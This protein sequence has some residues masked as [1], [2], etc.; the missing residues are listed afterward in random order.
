MTKTNLFILSAACLLALASC[1]QND[2]TP[3]SGNTEPATSA[4]SSSNSTAVSTPSSSSATTIESTPYVPPTDTEDVQMSVT[5]PVNPVCVTPKVQ[6]YIDAMR[7]QEQTLEHPYRVSALYGPEGFGASGVDRGDGYTGY[8][9][10]E[11]GGVD[12][13]DYLSRNDYSNTIENVP[14]SLFWTKD[15]LSYEKAFV[16]FWSKSDK[17]DLRTV[18]AKADAVSADLPNLFANTEYRFRV[19]ADGAKRYISQTGTFKTADYPRTMTMGGVKN[20]RDL[21]GYMTSY[22]KRVKQGLVYRGYEIIDESFSSHGANYNA[23]VEKVNQEVMQI[24]HEI[25]LKDSSGR[26]GRTKSCLT[27]AE[28]HPLEVVAYDSFF[29]N[30]SKA[31]VPEIFEILSKA[32]TEH[33]YFHCWGGADRTGMVAFFLNA[34]LGVSYTDLVIDFELTTETNNKRCHMHNSENAHF[35]KFL[36]A[37]AELPQFDKNKTVNEN[38]E[39][40]LT[41][42]FGIPMATIEKIRAAM[43]EDYS[44]DLAEVEPVYTADTSAW[45]ADRFGHWHAA[46][47]DPKVRCDYSRHNCVLDESKSTLPDCSHGGILVYTDPDCGYSYRK[48]VGPTDHEYIEVKTVTNSEGKTVTLKECKH[49]HARE[50]SIAYTDGTTY[51][52]GKAQSTVSTKMEKNTYTSWIIKVDKPIE[53][54]K[55]YF[56]GKTQY[57]SNM[58]RYFFNQNKQVNPKNPVTGED[59]PDQPANDPDETTQDAWRYMVSVNGGEKIAPKVGVTYREAGCGTGPVYLTDLDL[60]AG[61]NAIA[62]HQM[63]VGY[64]LT[65]SGKV[66]IRYE[67]D[68]TIEGVLPNSAVLDFGTETTKL[69]YDSAAKAYKASNISLDPAKPFKVKVVQDNAEYVLDADSVKSDSAALVEAGEGKAIK[70]KEAGVYDLVIDV[71]GIASGVANRISIAAAVP[72]EEI[73]FLWADAWQSDSTGTLDGKKL[74]KSGDDGLG[75]FTYRFKVNAPKAGKVTW[76]MTMQYS[77]SGKGKIYNEDGQDITVTGGTFLG[78][79]KTYEAFLGDTAG[80]FVEVAFAEIIVNAGENIIEFVVHNGYYRN[81]VD[82]TVPMRLVY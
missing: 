43:I 79:G 46:Q 61:E 58:D 21:G 4:V 55:I 76:Y 82:V 57:D 60:V 72:S 75:N 67:G 62:I 18:E 34:I 48:E 41:D 30:T 53:N 36:K 14:V 49:C 9:D 65:F 10:E 47:E 77:S 26:N 25:D 69:S 12:V 15:G 31:S 6:A 11:L 39:K 13:C 71:D 33:V 54:A 20:V 27:T 17:S 23:E 81:L 8:T 64:R 2:P 19:L 56:E 32:A 73:S 38:A 74:G 68:A 35:P 16:E 29:N 63:N 7:E 22:G 70:I 28:Y 37:L 45:K 42:Y 66:A 40:I 50:I 59:Y 5:T 52:G 51:S 44:E 78:S 24:K 3:S 80:V 1:G